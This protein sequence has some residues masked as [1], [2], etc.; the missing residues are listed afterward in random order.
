MLDIFDALTGVLWRDDSQVCHVAD[1]KKTY[2][3]APGVHI[4]IQSL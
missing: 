4:E 3:D 1:A 2:G